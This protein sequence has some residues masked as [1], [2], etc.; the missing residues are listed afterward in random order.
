MY[1]VHIATTYG[2]ATGVD[3]LFENK[4]CDF[5]FHCGCTWNWAG[6][7]NQCN[8]YNNSLPDR[9]KCPFCNA[10]GSVVILTLFY[11]WT[12]VLYWIIFA[13]QKRYWAPREILDQK[14][15]LLIREDSLGDHESESFI[16]LEKPEDIRE[17]EGVGGYLTIREIKVMLYE[18]IFPYSLLQLLFRLVITFHSYFIFG[19]ITA[20]FFKVGTGYPHFFW[21]SW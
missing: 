16:G 12:I 8:V 6:G 14:K 18:S 17:G 5:M 20:F 11:L 7:W 10:K 3:T 13:I 15:Q 4:Y 2:L 1:V 21:W 19:A 9:L